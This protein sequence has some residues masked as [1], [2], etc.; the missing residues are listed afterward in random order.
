MAKVEVRD[1]D[2]RL[3]PVA[4]GTELKDANLHSYWVRDSDKSICRH[5][6]KQFRFAST[7]DVL[8]G[9]DG[10]KDVDGR[11]RNGDL[12]LMVGPREQ[13]EK[14]IRD[15]RALDEQRDKGFQAGDPETGGTYNSGDNYQEYG[16]KR[17]QL[18]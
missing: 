13:V 10:Y 16:G 5:Q 9:H 4:K 8:E 6:Q 1:R 7:E 12:L 3:K 11:I 15:R 2:E 14:E 18:A 17:H